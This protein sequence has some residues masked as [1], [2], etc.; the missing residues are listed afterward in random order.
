MKGKRPNHS[1]ERTRPARDFKTQIGLA[2]PLSSKPLGG[3]IAMDKDRRSPVVK[4]PADA[5]DWLRRH[6]VHGIL[7]NRI[8]ALDSDSRIEAWVVTFTAV[9]ILAFLFIPASGLLGTILLVVAILRLYEILINVIHAT[10][11]YGVVDTKPMAGY[12]RIVILLFANLVEVV[13]W[14]GFIYRWFPFDFTNSS[15]SFQLSALSYSFSTATGV[16]S[17]PISAES[18][19]TV[20]ISLAESALGLFMIVAVLAKFV[21]SLAPSSDIPPN[22]SLER[23]GDSAPEAVDGKQSAN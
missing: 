11:F 20:I 15:V 9:S 17:P 18:N 22:N 2:G 16:G 4:K 14:F 6:T 10:I 1:L 3:I 7:K 19:S 23:T 21:S 5:V 12:R 13:F 8:G